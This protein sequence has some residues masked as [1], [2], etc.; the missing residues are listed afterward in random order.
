MSIK[1][2]CYNSIHEFDTRT[3]AAKF[4]EKCIMCSDGAEQSRY[5]HVLM[6][7]MNGEKYCS[8]E[9]TI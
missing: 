8:D 7:L 4:F 5:L 6:Q 9:T 1:C 3:Q 2:K